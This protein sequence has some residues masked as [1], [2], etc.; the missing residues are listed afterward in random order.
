MVGQITIGEI[1][2]VAIQEKGHEIIMIMG[3]I[4]E[5]VVTTEMVEDTQAE[6]VRCET[7]AICVMVVV[8]VD[9]GIIEFNNFLDQNL[10]F[11]F[12]FQLLI[13]NIS[14]FKYKIINCNY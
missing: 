3:M 2:D 10:G 7:M 12:E 1:I 9:I 4:A 8:M 14:S 6:I 13:F 11:C 5:T